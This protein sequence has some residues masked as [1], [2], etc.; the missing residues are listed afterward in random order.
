MIEIMIYE[1]DEKENL[2]VGVI[3]KGHAD[4]VALG[5]DIVC[6]A[7]STLVQ[8]AYMGVCYHLEETIPLRKSSGYLKFILKKA[9]PPEVQ[10]ILKTMELGLREIA[11]QYPQH[12]MVSNFSHKCLFAW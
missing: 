9:P 4:Y 6:S 10:A 12:V 11:E 8:V 7:V 2:I 5:D 1:N 3:S